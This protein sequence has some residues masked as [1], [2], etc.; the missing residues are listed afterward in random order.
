MT[1]QEMAFRIGG[2]NDF[3]PDWVEITP[4]EYA[5][6]VHNTS[7]L[8]TEHRQMY[9]KEG[10]T[11]GFKD[12]PVSGFLIIFQDLTGVATT[13][14]YQRV[15]DKLFGGYDYVTKFWSFGCNH[16]Y[17]EVPWDDKYG[18]RYNCMHLWRCTKCG[19]AQVIDSS[20]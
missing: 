11:N 10:R 2:Y 18:I 13:A 20:G 5:V 17:H 1:P 7:V 8:K 4:H 19:Q 14:D 16:Q 9:T 6:R 15:N 3:P 12:C